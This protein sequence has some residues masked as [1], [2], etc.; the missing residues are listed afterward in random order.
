MDIINWLLFPKDCHLCLLQ[1]SCKVPPHGVCEHSAEVMV[2]LV[3]FLSYSISSTVFATVH[4][5]SLT[6][7]IGR[8]LIHQSFLYANDS[9]DNCNFEHLIGYLLHSFEQHLDLF[10]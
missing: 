3:C 8:G 2:A 1:T 9:E 7:E 5:L 6:M 4:L 10:V